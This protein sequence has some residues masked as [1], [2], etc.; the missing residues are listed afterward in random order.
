MIY[1]DRLVQVPVPDPVPLGTELTQDCPPAATV[2]LSGPLTIGQI[3]MR[4]GAV[5]DALLVCR[6]Q[7]SQIRA[8]QPVMPA[9]HAGTPP[10]ANPAP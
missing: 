5:E 8:I 10:G 1:K 9:D 7:L 4:L 2:P 6:E 3:V